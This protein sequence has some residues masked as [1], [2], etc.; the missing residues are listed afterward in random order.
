MV[1]N[2]SFIPTEDNAKKI[3]SWRHTGGHTPMKCKLKHRDKPPLFFLGGCAFNCF[4]QWFAG[5]CPIDNTPW[6]RQYEIAKEKLLRYNIIIVLEKMKD[7]KY[8]AALE[9]YFGVP[10]ITQKKSSLCEP[11]ADRA[12]R[13]NP[14]TIANETLEILKDL[15]T[16]DTRLYKGL[17]DCLEDGEYNFPR[18]NGDRFYSNSTIQVHYNDFEKWSQEQKDTAKAK[19][20]HDANFKAANA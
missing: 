12:N 8:I 14:L 20:H 2:F 16:L 3:R 17:A 6:P 19:M 5:K 18:W 4:V 10:G 13:E 9:S 15:N 7:P 1:Y 11:E